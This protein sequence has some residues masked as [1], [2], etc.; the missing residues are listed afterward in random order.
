MIETRHTEKTLLFQLFE[1]RD[2]GNL[3]RAIDTLIAAMEPEDV[4][5]VEQ[6]YNSYKAKQ[7]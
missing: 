7:K 1:A 4:K 2:T 6:Q 5:L 3:E